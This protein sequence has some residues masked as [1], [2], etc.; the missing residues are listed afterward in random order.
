VSPSPALSAGSA[1][2]PSWRQGMRAACMPALTGPPPTSPQCISVHVDRSNDGALRRRRIRRLGHPRRYAP[3]PLE[4][5]NPSQ[6]VK[7]GFGRSSRQTTGAVNKTAV[8][9][10]LS[11]ATNASGAVRRQPPHI[12]TLMCT[13][14]QCTTQRRRRAADSIWTVEILLDA[15][16]GIDEP[17]VTQGAWRGTPLWYGIA[18]GCDECGSPRE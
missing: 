9:F 4:S 1:R 18:F 17:A 8:S 10:A 13:R 16:L 7:A 15:G 14:S 5:R 2:W 6:C 12:T 3:S 11:T